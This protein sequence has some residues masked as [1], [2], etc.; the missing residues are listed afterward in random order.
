MKQSISAREWRYVVLWT[1][2]LLAASCLPYLVAWLATPPGH[3]F[4]GLVINPLDGNS[5]LAK[6]R[7]GWAG[8]W[9]FHPRSHLSRVG[10]PTFSC[11][12][13]RWDIFRGLSA[14][15]WQWS[16]TRPGSWA[17]RCCCLGFTFSLPT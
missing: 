8:S 12:T 1:A 4:V 13:S 14:C 15:L 3:Q 2:L 9:Q 5:Y 6:I 10:E 17:A 7:E 16:T 11:T